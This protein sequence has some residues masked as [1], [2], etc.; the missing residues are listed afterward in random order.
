MLRD[1][2]VLLGILP[3]WAYWHARAE[4]GMSR[5]E[6]YGT[7]AI[8]AGAVAFAAFPSVREGG[9][10]SVAVMLSPVARSPLRFYQERW[11]RAVRLTVLALT[12]IG[13]CALLLMTPSLQS[14]VDPYSLPNVVS[15][16]ESQIST[17]EI[18]VQE[19]RAD[20]RALKNDQENFFWWL[21]GIGMIAL[22]SIIGFNLK[23]FYHDYERGRRTRERGDGRERAPD[24][25]DE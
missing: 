25:S 8:A 9:G 5:G 16:H 19:I 21:R 7:A 13:S 17:L 10:A 24:E 2:A 3:E 14:Q 6:I 12:I 11:F 4:W 1:I 15:R 20:V 18:S 22:T 23:T